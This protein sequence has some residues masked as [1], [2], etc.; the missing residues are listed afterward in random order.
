MK[1]VADSSGSKYSE[2]ISKFETSP[3]SKRG[4][5]ISPSVVDPKMIP[6]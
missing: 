5:P 6:G 2:I 3:Q 4:P 1:K